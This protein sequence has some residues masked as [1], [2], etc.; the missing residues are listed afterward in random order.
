MPNE[1]INKINY[2]ASFPDSKLGVAQGIG[3]V[4]IPSAGLNIKFI[5]K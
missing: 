5:Q 3:T 4:D 1:R 2:R